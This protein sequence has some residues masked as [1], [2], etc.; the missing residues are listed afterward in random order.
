MVSG[1]S[2]EVSG[3]SFTDGG[4]ISD[5]TDKAMES[6]THGGRRSQLRQATGATIS[7]SADATVVP[8]SDPPPPLSLRRPQGQMT[9]IAIP[10]PPVHRVYKNNDLPRTPTGRG[11]DGSDGDEGSTARGGE[12]SI[13]CGRGGSMATPATMNHH[14]ATQLIPYDGDPELPAT[15]N[16]TTTRPSHP[17]GQRRTTP[18]TSPFP[19]SPRRDQHSHPLSSLRQPTHSVPFHRNLGFNHHRGCRNLGL[20]FFNVFKCFVKTLSTV[21]ISTIKNSSDSQK[22]FTPH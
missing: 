13:A 20:S 18:A 4:E 11:I 1:Y 6:A 12:G 10:S 15:T 7:T 21:Y 3:D 9:A 22:I 14:H 16:Q 5:E 17:P 8:N 19:H 2:M